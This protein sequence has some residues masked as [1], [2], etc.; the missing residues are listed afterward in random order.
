MSVSIQIDDTDL[1]NIMKATALHTNKSIKSIVYTASIFFIQSARKRTKKARKGQKRE[2]IPRGTMK[3]F[4]IVV[5]K[6]NRPDKFIITSDKND[7]RRE[8][9]TIGAAKNSW[10][11]A[12]K[13]LGKQAAKIGNGSGIRLGRAIN[14]TQKKDPAITIINETSYLSVINPNIEAFAMGKTARRMEHNL[15]RVV[16]RKLKRLWK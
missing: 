6:Q 5:K 14:N 11:G 1:F 12:L 7:P 8:I 3:Q 10:N 4:N 16:K 15:D 2:L 9:K 13:A